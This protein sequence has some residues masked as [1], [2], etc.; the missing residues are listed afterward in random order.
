MIYPFV[1][2]IDFEKY[3]ICIMYYYLLSFYCFS[4]CKSSQTCCSG[5][6]TTSCMAS[7]N[8]SQC[9]CA[10]NCHRYTNEICCPDFYESCGM[11]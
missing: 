10:Y 6:S 7:R 3:L 5:S 4:G 9:S 11:Y 1:S 8:D 2:K